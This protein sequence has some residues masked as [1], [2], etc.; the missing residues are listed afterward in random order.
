MS[1]DDTKGW[2]SQNSAWGILGIG[3]KNKEQNQHVNWSLW[4]IPCQT[5]MGANMIEHF[6]IKIKSL[7]I[8]QNLTYHR[9]DSASPEL[10]LSV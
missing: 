6:S 1:V 2:N 10:F 8:I 4:A 5:Q 9:E 7:H 3:N